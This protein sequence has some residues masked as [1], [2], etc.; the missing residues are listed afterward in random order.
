MTTAVR[1]SVTI[2]VVFG[3]VA[4]L[5]ALAAALLAPTRSAASVS[6]AVNRI[7]RQD[8]AQYQFDEYY[9][10]QASNLFAE[11]VVSWF[12][13]PSIVQEI[14]RRAKVEPKIT[15]LDELASRFKTRKPS[16]QNIVI[17]FTAD[18]RATAEAL[19]TALTDVV[20]ERTSALNQSA[21]RKA[22]FEIVSPEPVITEARPNAPIQT[23]AG[24]LAGLLIGGLVATLPQYLSLGSSPAGA[25][26][27]DGDDRR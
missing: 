24:L 15:S 6:L 5:A 20:R 21:D 17:R 1:K 11:T 10:L 22:L 12:S 4:A 26:L 25:R 9:A 27:S 3:L 13:T 2:T 16:S 18:D 23:A 19:S 8:T 7:N 14:Y